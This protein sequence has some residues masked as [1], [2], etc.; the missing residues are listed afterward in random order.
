MDL[1]VAQQT[2]LVEESLPAL[3]ACVRPLFLMD[4]LVC[5]ESRSVGEALSAVAGVYSF[6]LVSLEVPVEVAGT[7]ETQVTARTF[8]RTLHLIGVLT[9]GLQVPHQC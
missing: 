9:V 6:F 7:A 1:H 8:V 5:R 4:A 3:C 2:T